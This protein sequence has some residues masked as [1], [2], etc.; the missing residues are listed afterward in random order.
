MPAIIIMSQWGI[1]G[2]MII[3]LAGLQDVP[4]S[5]YDAAS[6]DGAG[7]IATFWN[8]TLPMM[9]PTLFFSLVMGIIGSWQMFTQS[10]IMTGGGPDN[11]TLT[12]VLLL[13][14]RAF[15]G[16]HFGK[17]SAMAWILFV[18]ILAFTLLILRSSAL[19]VYYEGDVRK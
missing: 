9:T 19:W 1:G 13:Y 4:Q 14:N 18:I 7:T 12:A 2:S 17:A 3:F 6:I 10:F 8:I 11:A 15:Q 16:F 5:L